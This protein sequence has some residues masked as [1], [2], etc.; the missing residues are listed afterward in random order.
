MLYKLFTFLIICLHCLISYIFLLVC[1]E[2]VQDT[3]YS[4]NAYG[5]TL[6]TPSIANDATI[7][8]IKR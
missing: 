6:L 5:I 2:I 3:V 7:R 8:N 1:E 4:V